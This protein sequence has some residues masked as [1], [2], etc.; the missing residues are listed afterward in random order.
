[1]IRTSLAKSVMSSEKSVEAYKSLANVERAF[2]SLKTVDLEIRPIYHRL[3]DRVRS[4]VFLCMLAYYVEWQMKQKL[5]PL[6]F[7]EEDREG[8]KNARPDIVSPAVASKTTQ[9]KARLHVTEEGLPVQTFGGL[10][11]DLGTLVK[12]VMQAGK[13]KAT[14]FSM[15]TES[16]PLQQKALALLGVSLNL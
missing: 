8:A 16:T 14:R 7:A 5:A 15:L 10:L 3:S 4:H 9:K 2:R 6:L 1:M 11:E 13:E 12:N